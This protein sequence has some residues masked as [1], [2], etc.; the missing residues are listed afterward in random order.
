MVNEVF[1]VDKMLTV[2]SSKKKLLEVKLK[3][4]EIFLFNYRQ[5]IEKN[6]AW[7][8]IDGLLFPA[9]SNVYNEKLIRKSI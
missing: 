8:L 4:R 3:W 1:K 9:Q 6:V 7:I 5:K 2:K